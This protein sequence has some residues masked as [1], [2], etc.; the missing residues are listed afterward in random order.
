MREVGAFEA[1]NKLSQLLD[2]VEGGEEVII[3]RHGKRQAVVLGFKEWERLAKVPSFGQLLMSAP[4]SDAD[5]PRRNRS[6][7]RRVRL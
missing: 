5:L 4:L 3:T 7:L 2:L 1:K 6:P